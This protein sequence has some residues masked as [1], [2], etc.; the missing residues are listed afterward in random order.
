MT[1][2]RVVLGSVLGGTTAAAI[3]GVAQAEPARDLSATAPRSARW[4]L[5]NR[6]ESDGAWADFLRG[7]DLVWHRL[8]T[9][10]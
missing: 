1:S 4:Q 9:L 2:R 3:P 5:R 6:M 8:P 7:Q 10:W